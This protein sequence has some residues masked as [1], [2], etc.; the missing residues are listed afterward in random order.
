MTEAKLVVLGGGGV[1]CVCVRK[2][3]MFVHSLCQNS[4]QLVTHL[5]DDLVTLFSSCVS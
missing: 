2:W 5:L 1:M 3:Q 4:S